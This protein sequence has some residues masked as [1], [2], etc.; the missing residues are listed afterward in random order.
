[1]TSTAVRRRV[2][3][4]VRPD[5]DDSQRQQKQ[6]TKREQL[7]KEQQHLGR[8]MARLKRAFHAV[9]KQQRRVARIERQVAI[10]EG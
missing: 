8:W 9:E 10:L 2:L 7:R 6:A 4:P 1:M 3:R 5:P